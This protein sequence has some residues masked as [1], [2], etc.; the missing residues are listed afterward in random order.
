MFRKGKLQMDDEAMGRID[1]QASEIRSRSIVFVEWSN[2]GEI[3]MWL[4]CRIIGGLQSIPW[5]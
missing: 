3:S 2:T 1:L 4:L 5:P